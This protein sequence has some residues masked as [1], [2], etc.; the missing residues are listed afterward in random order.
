MRIEHADTGD[1]LGD[2]RV[3]IAR[4]TPSLR[5]QARVAIRCVRNGAALLDANCESEGSVVRQG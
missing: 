3:Q 1:T 2:E 4:N 5:L